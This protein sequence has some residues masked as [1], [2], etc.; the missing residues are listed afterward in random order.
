[1]METERRFFFCHLQKTAGTTLIRRIRSD[2]PECAVY[3]LPTDGDPIARVISV[4][5]L[6]SVWAERG[7][8]IRVVT[9]HFPLCTAELLGGE[10]TTLT[11]L[12]HPV[13]RTMSYV[14][15]HR[16]RT[17]EDADLTLEQ[18]YD[19]EF[20]F[21]GLI[22]NHMTKMLSLVPAEMDDGALTRVSFTPERLERAKERL[23]GVDVVGIQEDFE[24]FCREL[25]ER[26]GW[27]LAD[28]LSP[29]PRTHADVE[30]AFRDRILED[31]AHDVEL[32]EFARRLVADRTQVPR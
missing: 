7:E 13:E 17:P 31:N 32:Y 11:V 29:A 6:L 8:E 4:E 9:G 20:R 18:V 1:M 2:F 19:D 5:N 3:P 24:S 26:F 15:H 28:S 12:R 10:F 23:A 22:H 16:R 14:R 21:H 27:S 25:S 30:P